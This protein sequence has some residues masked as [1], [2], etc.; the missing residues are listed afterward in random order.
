[1]AERAKAALDAIRDFP[2]PVI[3]ALNGNAMGGGAELA[4][5]CD[6]RVA[7]QHARIGFVQGR[8]NIS[9]AWG[10]GVALV[11]ADMVDAGAALGLGLVDAVADE[12]QSIDAAIEVF[13]APFLW[14]TPQV[15]RAF[16][17]LAREARRGAARSELNALETRN[18]AA[19]WAHD[20]HWA[21]ADK[22]LAKRD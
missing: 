21:A 4:V 5:S 12:G 19:T 14:Q 3:A 11:R 9:T 2:L 1:M 20:D 6:F 18:F 7:A 8:L 17:A 10:G 13:Q 15:L 22:V 16:K